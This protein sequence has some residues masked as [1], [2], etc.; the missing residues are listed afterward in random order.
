MTSSRV[1]PTVGGLVLGFECA[2]AYA[3][4]RTVSIGHYRD[5]EWRNG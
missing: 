1:T 3:E 2:N 5:K 4:R